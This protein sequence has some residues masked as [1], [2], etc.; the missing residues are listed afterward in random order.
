MGLPREGVR[1]SN[2][3]KG[4]FGP[5]KFEDASFHFTGG[6]VELKITVTYL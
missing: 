4:R 3:A 2:N 6:K 1:A 5:P